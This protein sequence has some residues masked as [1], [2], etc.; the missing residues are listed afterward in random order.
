[1][2]WRNIVVRALWTFFQG[3]VGTVTVLPYIT[4]DT[5]WQNV[6]NGAIAGGL[7]ALL[8]FL[9][10]LAQEMVKPTGDARPS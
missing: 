2:N 5:G 9:K 3:A 6:A 1:M 4:D 10:T 8:S 7:A